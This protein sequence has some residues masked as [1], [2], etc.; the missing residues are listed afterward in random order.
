MST[1]ELW[2]ADVL[3]LQELL[4]KRETSSLEAVQTLLNRIRDLD[5]DGPRLGSVLE[6]SEESLEA[7][8]QL[9]HERTRS[10][11]GPLHG[12]PVL[13]KDNIETSGNMET[14][15]GSLALLGVRVP[16]D[17]FI[18]DRLRG[19]GAVVLGKNN[20]SEWANFRSTHS[21]SGWSARGGQTKN[22]HAL[23]RSPCGSS[24]GSAASVAAGL[25][26]LAI[27]TETDGS[28]LCPA[29][30]NGVV[31][32][33]PTVGLTSRSG[34]IPVSN[35][36]DT[37]GPFARTVAGA[38]IA[39]SVIAG[40]DSEDSLTQR[41]PRSANLNYTPFLREDGL[42]GA[43][44]GVA[45]DVY[46]G[47]SPKADAVVESAIQALREGGAT[48]IDPADIPTAK[49]MRDGDEEMKVLLYEFKHGLEQYFQRRSPGGPR[50]L[51]DIVSFNEMNR[52][53][54]MPFF[55]QEIFLQALEKG[56]LSE[57]EY[58]G[59]RS[60]AIKLARDQGIDAVMDA[61]NLDA[62]VMPT[63]G[64]AFPIDLLNGD[65]FT[66][67]SPQPAAL[68]GYPAISVPAGD[69]FG[70]P[71]GITFMG[72]AFSEATLIRLAYAYE[73]ATNAVRWPSFQP[74]VGWG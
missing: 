74:T 4:A 3:Q 18:V 31:G 36:Q 27:G 55:G 70:L 6:V 68:A 43:R 41:I 59:A 16:G 9:D 73:Q 15:A 62:L 8:R 14:T 25:A 67:G 19:A 23:D 29:A 30:M 7:A 40:R 44:I 11:R 32:I 63:T 33:K 38:A 64:P 50:N 21:S 66:G 47:Y 26:P 56:D 58:V 48:I 28:I 65:H 69:A 61:H 72:R 42:Q 2:M 71:V 22:P 12:I 39:L 5:H 1:D 34:V 20:L 37:V 54:E 57:P 13:I 49:Q 51:A 60:T 46:F 52:D 24:S 53:R 17:A 35:S 45:R 10:P